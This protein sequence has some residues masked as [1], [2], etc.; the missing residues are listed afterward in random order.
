MIKKKNTSNHP[1]WN[2]R[3]FLINKRIQ[4]VWNVFRQYFRTF[5]QRSGCKTKT[6]LFHIHFYKYTTKIR[7]TGGSKQNSLM[8]S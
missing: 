4:P 8:P 1:I 7:Y 5:L 6:D 2:R 3:Y